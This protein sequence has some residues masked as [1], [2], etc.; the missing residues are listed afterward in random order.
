MYTYNYICVHIYMS[1][2]AQ[3]HLCKR[4]HLIEIC[5]CCFLDMHLNSN[6]LSTIARISSLIILEILPACFSCNNNF[7]LSQSSLGSDD[8]NIAFETPEVMIAGELGNFIRVLSRVDVL[9]TR[10]S[11]KC[12]SFAKSYINFLSDKLAWLTL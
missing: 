12:I 1:K 11:S 3:H 8:R 5:L 9:P 4:L 7:I 10:L 6:N 2:Y